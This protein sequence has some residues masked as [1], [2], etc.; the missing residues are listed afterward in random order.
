MAAKPLISRIWVTTSLAL[1]SQLGCTSPSICVPPPPSGGSCVR[2]A[3][4][5]QPSSFTLS[6]TPACGIVDEDVTLIQGRTGAAV[7][8]RVSADGSSPP[9]QAVTIQPGDDFDGQFGDSSCR[10]EICTIFE[11]EGPGAACPSASARLRP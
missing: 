11:G 2:F 1:A 5:A 3:A 9:S 7:P 8:L 10:I 4:A 6:I